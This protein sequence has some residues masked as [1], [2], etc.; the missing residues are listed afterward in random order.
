MRL[1]MPN[2]SHKTVTFFLVEDDDVD[3]MGF[4]RAL[5]RQKIANPL[6]V[7]R[8]GVEA[9]ERLRGL[10]GK[11][12]LEQPYIILLDLNM[13]RMNGLEFLQEIRHD[14]ELHPAIVFVITTS[15]DEK[16]RLAAYDQNVAGYI[17]KSE[18]GDSIQQA[19]DMLDHYWRVVE[20]P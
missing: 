11:E 15:R 8:D 5:K 14:E 16:D 12:K 6:E 19:L 20:F 1:A 9:L 13:P 18:P 4:E 7:A 2:K 10:N 17:V 3:V